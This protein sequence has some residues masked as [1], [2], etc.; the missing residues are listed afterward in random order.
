MKSQFLAAAFAAAALAA[1]V[2]AASA[3]DVVI[4]ICPAYDWTRTVVGTLIS[5]A[6]ALAMLSVGISVTSP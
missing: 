2:L 5:V 6:A 1:S 4:T 3:K